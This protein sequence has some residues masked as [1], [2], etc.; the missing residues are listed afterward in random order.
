MTIDLVHALP[1]IVRRNLFVVRGG[2]GA[3]DP[4]K[5]ARRQSIGIRFDKMDKSIEHHHGSPPQ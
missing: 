3:V 1:E 5:K 2:L 4:V